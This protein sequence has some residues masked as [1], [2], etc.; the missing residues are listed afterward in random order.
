[1]AYSLWGSADGH[2]CRHGRGAIVLENAMRE[3]SSK[4]TVWLLVENAVTR[5]ENIVIFATF[6]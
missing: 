4:I 1:M 5:K 2:R 3:G 6:I